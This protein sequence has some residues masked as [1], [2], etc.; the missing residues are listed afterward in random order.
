M[1]KIKGN[2]SYDKELDLKFKIIRVLILREF[3]PENYKEHLKEV[4]KLRDSITNFLDKSFF[5]DL[6]EKL[7]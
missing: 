3:N 7:I 4:I 6:N 2:F 1:N 5:E